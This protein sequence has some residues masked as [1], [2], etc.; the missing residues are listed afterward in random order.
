MA[1]DPGRPA[2]P[3]SQMLQLLN[4][5]LTAQAIYVAA[6]LGIADALADESRTIDDLASATGAN[7]GSLYRLLRMLSGAGIFR[8]EADGRFALTPLGGCLRSEGPDS[9]RDWALY[10]GS[11][12]MWP[13]WGGLRESVMTGAAAF[14]RM[15]GMPLWDYMAEHPELGTPFNR[16]MSR[17]SEQHNAALIASYD[18]SSFAAVADIGGGQGS[19]LAAILRAN[20][21]LRGI[22]FDLP[23]VVKR[24]APLQETG[25]LD[26]CAVIGGDMLQGVPVGADAYVVKRV[27]M[28]W[29]DEQAARILRSCADAMPEDGRILV[30][31]MVLPPRNDPGPG[32]TF[33]L[34]MLLVHSGARI[35]TEAEFG[36]LFSA[37]GLR[38]NRIIPT[39]SPNTIL[40]GVRA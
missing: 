23:E 39:T 27:L 6:T 31:E 9:V 11:P 13:V 32:K 34:L 24:P 29:G 28:D 7:R 26:R 21:S 4:G 40:E 15:H 14:P 3:S 2:N 37:A 8:E 22:L 19:T 35:R 38:L 18:F 30:V 20:P 5:F 17:Q 1:I 12:A 25:A 36:D 10:A 16:W 33:D